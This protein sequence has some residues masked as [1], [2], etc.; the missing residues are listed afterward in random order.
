M[1]VDESCH[2]I[3]G[4]EQREAV[5]MEEREEGCDDGDELRKLLVPDVR[6]LPIIPPTAVE[7]NFDVYFAPGISYDLFSEFFPWCLHVWFFWMI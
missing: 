2:R 6:I 3:E 7:S 4:K 5:R 1:G